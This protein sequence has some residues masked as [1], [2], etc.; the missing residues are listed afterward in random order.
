MPE[1]SISSGLHPVFSAAAALA[2]SVQSRPT[3]IAYE[4]KRIEGLTAIHSARFG[5][6]HNS[7]YGQE[8]SSDRAMR[9]VTSESARDRHPHPLVRPH[10]ETGRLGLFSC[11]GYIV[12]IEG[13][14]DDE[15]GEILREVYEWQTRD[16]F[17]YRHR[18]EPQMLVMWDNR[19]VLHRATGGYEGHERL[20]H[21]TS[22][23][24]TG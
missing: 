2:R 20:L 9:I 3:P 10:P 13:I 21:R 14:D 17:V 24:A 22:I 1:T 11:L 5:Y 8:D 7:I 18:W 15:A 6:A 23:G 16:E 19:S 4:K 12:G